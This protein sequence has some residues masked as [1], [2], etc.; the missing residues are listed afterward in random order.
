[1]IFG[2]IIFQVAMTFGMLT[3]KWN[4]NKESKKSMV[5]MKIYKV[6][7]LLWGALLICTLLFSFLKAY[8]ILEKISIL[9]LLLFILTGIVVLGIGVIEIFS[10]QHS[11]KKTSHKWTRKK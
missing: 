2:L 3:R 10:Y 11:R 4:G 8:T 6:F 1:M 9:N 5:G 7:G